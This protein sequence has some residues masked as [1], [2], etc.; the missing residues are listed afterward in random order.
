MKILLYT[1]DNMITDIERLDDYIWIHEVNIDNIFDDWMIVLDKYA[2]IVTKINFCDWVF[3]NTIFS[4]L[5]KLKKEW[6]TLYYKQ[7]HTKLV[8]RTR[9]LIKHFDLQVFVYACNKDMQEYLDIE[10]IPYTIFDSKK[11]L[12]STIRDEVIHKKQTYITI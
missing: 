6:D 10:C 9:S 11:L 3:V 4:F 8:Q 5:Y 2:S 1:S 12:L 7:L